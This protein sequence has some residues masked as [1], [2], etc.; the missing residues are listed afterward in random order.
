MWLASTHPP[1][2]TLHIP[3]EGRYSITRKPNQCSAHHAITAGGSPDTV[4]PLAVAYALNSVAVTG[5][6]P[7]LT[8][9]MTL[10][11]GQQDLVVSTMVAGALVGSVAAGWAT[12][13]FGRWLT[14]VL[15]DL[16]FIAG[17]VALF[18]AHNLGMARAYSVCLP[19]QRK[20]VCRGSKLRMYVC[21]C[22]FFLIFFGD[23][24][25]D[26]GETCTSL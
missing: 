24:P 3:P 15:T 19:C 10:S 14:I 20:G 26:Q 7:A 12:D 5:A 6:L 8:K 9:E 16:I 4:V 11:L 22:V 23:N 1:D 21:V 2:S 13:T 18:T 25:T 17:G